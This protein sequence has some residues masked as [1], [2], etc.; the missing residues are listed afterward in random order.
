MRLLSGSIL[1]LFVCTSMAC[2][3]ALPPGQQ[4]FNA[5]RT[6]V[7]EIILRGLL[8]SP[9]VRLI[10]EPNLPEA[11][12]AWR[13]YQRSFPDNPTLHEELARC[14]AAVRF[15]TPEDRTALT[16]SPEPWAGTRRF[17]RQWG[18]LTVLALVSL[19]CASLARWWVIGEQRWVI[20]S[21]VVFAAAGLV[22]FGW[23]IDHFGRRAAARV[24]VA[25]V[26][27]AATLRTGDGFEF[28]ARRESPLPAGVEAVVRFER[29]NWLQVELADGTLGW[30][31]R[32]AVLTLD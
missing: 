19:A 29:K 27:K 23:L 20:G 25:V 7:F 21:T 30:L 13:Q 17:A 6:K 12:L 14:R 31:P 32:T 8:S 28:P 24:P 18:V 9:S 1:V 22:T 3:N 5:P 16:P 11:I 2:A 10:E 15:A 4:Q 26:A